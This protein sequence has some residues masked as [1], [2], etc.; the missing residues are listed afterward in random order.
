MAIDIQKP[1]KK[2]LPY[3]LKAQEENLNEADTI[4]RL[5]KVFEEV[6]GYDAM[7]EITHEKKVKEKYV[8]I[9]IK[10][11]GA[12]R[13]LVEAKA[14]GTVLRD[15]H[16]EQAKHYAAEDN[17]R[18][19]LLTNGVAWNL[20]HLSF[21]EGIEY[22][23]VFAAD[24]ASEP[25]EKAVELLGLLHRQSIRNGHHEEFWRRRAALSPESI[26]KALF[27]EEALRFI[28]R[29]IR[30]SQRMLVDEEDLASAI[31]TMF[32][33][34][35]RERI[36]PLKIHRKKKLKGAKPKQD[37]A[38]TDKS[39]APSTPVVSPAGGGADSRGPGPS[40]EKGK[41]GQT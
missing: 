16:I 11:D 37:L 22:E 33:P 15:R 34:E 19:V 12:V 17:I 35:A 1:L 9:A 32:S 14:A 41:T 27:T 18:W 8:D 20:Y 30:R 21:E 10:L 40:A 13:L 6:L 7:T 39:A 31:H 38:S 24:L 23:R 2:L 4:A 25:L 36:G 3:L 28:R 29:E 26:G 5:V